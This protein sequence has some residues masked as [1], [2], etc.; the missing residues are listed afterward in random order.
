MIRPG[1]AVMTRMRETPVNDFFARNGR[2]RED[3]LMVHDMYVARVKKPA[4]SKYPWDYYEIKATAP[5]T[6]AFP[7]L[8][9]STCA[10]LK[11]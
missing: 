11:K 4:E 7:P 10:L 3:G 9:E 6:E 5:A 2:I 1:L 8:S